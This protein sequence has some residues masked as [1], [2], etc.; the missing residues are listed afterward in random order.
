M[1][2]P[3]ADRGHS[4]FPF[5]SSSVDLTFTFEPSVPIEAVR[6]TNR[7][8][9]FFLSSESAIA[10]RNAN[11]SIR[12]R[13]LLRRNLFTQVLCMLIL[14]AG[15]FFALLILATQTPSALGS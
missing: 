13:F 1:Q 6:I 12:L 9:G 14:V 5:D 4:R 11:G 15:L 2:F 10:D 3:A 8:P 7:I